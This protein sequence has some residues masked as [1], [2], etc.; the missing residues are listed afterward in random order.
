MRESTDAAHSNFNRG[1]EH[2]LMAEAKA[3]NKDIELLGLVYAWP[4]WVNPGGTSP[5]GSNLTEQNAADYMAAWVSGVKTSHNL[6]IDWVGIWN[7]SPV[8]YPMSSLPLAL[9]YPVEAHVEAV[10]FTSGLARAR[11]TRRRT[12]RR[13]ARHWMRMATGKFR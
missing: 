2:W 10:A 3:R 5:Y 7:E 8:K 12:S 11:S 4:S 6:T 1:Y 9:F 13:C